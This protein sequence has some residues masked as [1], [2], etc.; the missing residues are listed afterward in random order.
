VEAPTI[1]FNLSRLERVMSGPGKVAALGEELQRRGLERA[2]IVTGTTLGGSTLLEAV[3]QAAGARCAAVFKGARQHVPRSSVKELEVLIER[4]DAD[5]LV[6]FGGGSPIDT[7]KVA[8]YAFL[9]KREITHIAIPTTLSAGEYTHAGGVTD[10]STL[11]K[12]A[13]SDPRLQARTVIADPT[14][15]LQTPD[16]LWIATGM[17]ALDHAIET[18]YTPR[19]HPLSDALAAKAITLLI[20]HLRASIETSGTEQL[21]HRGFCQFA[22]WFSIYGSMNTR[23]GISHLLGHQ[24][25][26]RWNVAHGVTSCITLPHAM[27]LMAEIAPERFGPIAQGFGVAFN[28]ARPKAGALAC[29]ERT[30]Q[31]IA[32]FGVP[33][34]LKDAGVPHEEMGEIVPTVLHEVER[35]GVVDRRLTEK[36][37]ANLLEAAY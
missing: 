15:T 20:E 4:T 19:H 30:A 24:I 6:S 27:R 9:S 31:F 34:T 29:A 12:S 2:V 7:S 11:V 13:V 5:G 3:K 32:Q 35:S 25:G 14:L 8:S 26:P 23:F 28:P 16:W 10:E 17:R 37:V 21:A 33:H 36:D 18:I 22:A 1:D